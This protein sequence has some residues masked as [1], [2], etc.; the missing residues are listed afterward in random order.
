MSIETRTILAK[1][2]AGKLKLINRELFQLIDLFSDE[3]FQQ[4]PFDNGWSAAQVIDHVIKV[5]HRIINGVHGKVSETSR[6]ISQHIAVTRD[7]FLNF[8]IKIDA[9]PSALPS[10]ETVSKKE[11]IENIKAT[12]ERLMAA[13]TTLDLTMTCH[14]A[15]PRFADFTRL[16]LLHFIVYH[17][18]RHI[19][20]LKNIYR[21]INGKI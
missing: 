11:L 5:D 18:Q 10:N 3:Q 17:T 4:S 14:E 12:R 9:P 21:H 19:H 7:E 13:A 16:E 20:Q 1:D 6:N 2:I 15:P 8:N